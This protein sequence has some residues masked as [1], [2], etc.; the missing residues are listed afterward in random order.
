MA[1]RHLV[2]AL[3]HFLLARNLCPVLPDPHRFI[4][5]SVENL[6][7]ADSRVTYLERVRLLVPNS[8]ELWYLCGNEV[9]AEDPD[10]A[11]SSWRRSLELS[12]DYLSRILKKSAR[13]LT[14]SEILERVLP[15]KPDCLVEAAFQLYPQSAAERRPFLE[16]ALDPLKTPP[17]PRNAGDWHAKARI[18]KGLGQ[19]LESLAAYRSAIGL[20]PGQVSWRYEFAQLLYQEGQVR[21]ARRELEAVLAQQPEHAAARKLLAAEAEKDL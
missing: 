19:P 21:E 3:K 17:G 4:A 11:W 13:Y 20:E 2:P 5:D 9:L 10:R 15:D 16:K 8:A 14:P 6:E 12:P 18:H 7:R 1:R